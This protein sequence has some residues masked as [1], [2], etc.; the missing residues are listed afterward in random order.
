MDSFPIWDM[1]G[2]VG[3]V[4]VEQVGLYWEYRAE[5]T[6]PGE[7]FPRLYFHGKTEPPVRL[8]VFRPEENAAVLRGKISRRALGLTPA[9]GRFSLSES[10]WGSVEVPGFSAPV[11]GV[12]METGYRLLFWEE[13]GIPDEA[14][15]RFCFF[16][17]QVIAGRPCFLLSVDERGDPI[18]PEISL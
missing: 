7:G 3:T 2:P 11:T 14:V 16:R 6:A 13:D 15:S 17:R 18:L 1:T 5:L 4:T 8:G 9:E 12:K 10:L